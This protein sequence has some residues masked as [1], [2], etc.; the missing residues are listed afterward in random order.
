MLISIDPSINYCGYA[1]WEETIGK[2]ITIPREYGLIRPNNGITDQY[3]KAFSVY[4]KI[5]KLAD[6]L[7]EKY[8]LRVGYGLK[9]VMEVPAHWNIE[10]FIARESGNLYKLIF[11]CGQL[12]TVTDMDKCFLVFPHKWKG[13]MKKE[14]IRNRLAQDYGKVDE[15]FA[16]KI[17][18]MNHNIM[19]AIGIGYW[20]LYKREKGKTV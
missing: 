9:M 1:V 5:I 17:M 18:D 19:D 15:E 10:G 7:G 14:V 3:E 8:N 2:T 13:Q 20:Y 16:Q 11:L 6:G 4:H 12:S